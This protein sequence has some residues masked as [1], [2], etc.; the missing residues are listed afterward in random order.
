MR[1]H[2]LRE[3]EGTNNQGNQDAL[4]RHALPFPDKDIL[5]IRVKFWERWLPNQADFVEMEIPIHP[6]VHKD[7]RI[8]FIRAWVDSYKQLTYKIPENMNH[9]VTILEYIPIK[10][11]INEVIE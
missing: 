3:I 9:E 11:R 7:N 6:S 2:P 10:R 4:I 1:V 5:R 8:V